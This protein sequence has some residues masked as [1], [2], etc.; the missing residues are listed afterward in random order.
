MDASYSIGELA[1]QT[2]VAVT[3]I[4]FYSDHGI[5]P[6][7]ARTAA[8]Y[9]RYT[10]TDRA[11]LELVRTLRDLGF[12]LPTVAAVLSGEVELAEVAAERAQALAEHIRLQR[13]RHSVLLAVAE[14]GLNPEELVQMYAREVVEEFLDEVFDRP[15]FAGI[16]A[17]MT[18]YLPEDPEPEQLAAWDELAELTRDEDFRAVMRALVGRHDP[19]VLRRDSIATVLDRVRGGSVDADAVRELVTATGVT[20][21]HL[22]LVNDPRRARY[23][24]LLAIINGWAAPEPLSP[25]LDLAIAALRSSPAS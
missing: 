1:R 24:E 11:R 8:G 9:R 16:R 22:E 13:V 10:E 21:R 14:R 7:A 20:I 6:P 25:A 12:D 2:G 23:V 15:G 5:L 17:T 18:P 3:A 19:T 4:R